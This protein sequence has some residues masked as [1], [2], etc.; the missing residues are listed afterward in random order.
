MSDLS[1]QVLDGEPEW[2]DLA[3]WLDPPPPEELELLQRA[4]GPVLDVGCGPG[5]HVAE[6]ARRG[7]MSLG[8]DITPAM[9]ALAR[10]RG[11]R[12]LERSVFDHVPGAGR[13]ATVLLLDGNL[14]IGA[15]PLAMLRRVAQLL[16]PGG[17]LLAELTL[18]SASRP[19]LVRLDQG[20]D[21]G[22]WFSWREIGADWLGKLEAGPFAVTE[23][24]N[25]A[26]RVFAQLDLPAG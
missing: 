12:V 18:A 3:R 8:I 11:A 26:G 4:V 19:C 22:R 25:S 15:D 23:V 20:T 24:W 21:E 5:R 17:R 6:L 16:S 14:G 1:V 10:R 7:V 13:W 9:V 2:F